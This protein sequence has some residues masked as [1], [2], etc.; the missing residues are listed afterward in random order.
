ML[1][2]AVVLAGCQGS[3]G[4]AEQGAG[5]T[6]QVEQ[7]PAFAETA[8]VV[9]PGHKPMLPAYKLP[10]DLFPLKGDSYDDFRNS[11]PEIY[12]ITN[13]PT[14]GVRPVAEYEPS[15]RLMITVSDSSL[16]SGIMQNL[17]DVVKQSVGIVDIYVIYDSASIKTFFQNKL[18]SAG[19]SGSSVNWVNLSNE[20]VWVRDYGP[21]PIL[22]NDGKVGMVDFRYYHERIEDD[23]VPAKLASLWNVTAYRAPVDFEGGN[24]M[25][26]TKGN[27]FA[28]QGILWYNGSA[29]QDQIAGYMKDYVG[30]QNLYIV[31]PL[32]GEG[33][34]HIDMQA[35]IVDDKTVVVGEY[36][37]NQDSANY[38][39]TNDNAAYIEGLGYNVVRMPMP[40]NSDG[41]FRTYIN[42]LFVNNVNLVPVYSIDKAKETQ[43]MAVWK[44]VMPTWT[45]VALNSD[46]VIK[47]AGA[48][49]CI[50]MTTGKGT[51]AKIDANPGYA[52]GGDWSC[53]PGSST[54]SCNGVSYQGCCEGALLK[55]CENGALK[56]QNCGNKP[57]CG[58]DAQNQFYNCGTNG[59]SD[60]SGKYPKACGGTCQPNCAGKSC[61][62]DG[63]G[64]SC[65]TCPSGQECSAGKC[66]PSSDCK[67]PEQPSAETCGSVTDVGCCDAKGRVTYCQ[68]G[69][70]YCID[71][72]SANP[73]CGWNAQNGWYD[74]GT[75]G[76]AD[77]SDA[78]PK[79]CGG[80]CQP[81]CTGKQCG[82]NGCGGSCGTCQAGYSC[83][84]GK[85]VGSC[86]PSC[87]G[88]Q[89]GDNGCGGSCGTCQAG[90]SCQSGKCVSTCQPSC[91]GKSCGDDGCGGSCGTCAGGTVCQFGKC[92]V[93]DD[94]C[95]GVSFEGCCD[96]ATLHWCEGGQVNT[97]ECGQYGCGWNAGKQYYDCNQT[98]TDPSGA[99]PKECP[100]GVCIPNC[101]GKLCGDDGCGGSCGTCP[102]GTACVSGKCVAGTSCGDVTY[103]GKC[104]GNVLVWC[105]DDVL[106]KADCSNLGPNFK[107]EYYQAYDGYYCVEHPDC[108][109][110]CTDKQCGD[111]GCGGSCGPCPAGQ[112]CDAGKCKPGQCQP[113]CAGKQCGDDGCGGSCGV[114]AAGQTCKSGKCEAA[115]VPA[116]SGKD[117]G[118]DGCGGSCGVCPASFTCQSSKCLPGCNPDCTAKECGD[119]GCGGLCGACQQGQICTNY[120]CKTEC[121]PSCDGRQCGPDG[122]GG[123]CGTCPK[124]YTCSEEGTCV[125]APEGCGNITAVGMCDGDS[126]KKCVANTVVTINCA[127]TGKVCSFVP[128]S[129][130]YDC[131]SQCIPN[132]SGKKCGPDG[133]NGTCGV[134]GK[135]TVCENYSCVEIGPQCTPSCSGKQCGDDSCG[136]SCGTCQDGF[137]CVTGMCVPAEEDADVVEQ[138]AAPGDDTGSSQQPAIS[139]DSSGCAAGRVADT[140]AGLPLLLVLLCLWAGRVA[141]R[142]FRTES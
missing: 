117:C 6:E 119:D 70:L 109:P 113:D 101:A 102:Q 29:S 92:V 54:D 118:P 140:A 99:N 98:G 131:V 3:G 74:C 55:W 9:A 93:V 18:T 24:F 52:C 87:T 85:C 114:C 48:I 42:S 95:F 89:C 35:K 67:G 100:G 75:N 33:T 127:D 84:S 32:D 115:C 80:T 104:E 66:V 39:I 64:G 123:S 141:V 25:A 81:N 36:L 77:P 45:H 57:Q 11:H 134:C 47:W 17:V 22:S 28:S 78:N 136:G 139:K 46:D 138:D 69:K 34:T 116:C 83:Q 61:G 10:G 135:G 68:N 26:D 94:P 56:T 79:A 4:S 121:K 108:Q 97:L 62:D 111:D 124:E 41:N 132:C 12:G 65:G 43:A 38:K 107:C 88:K 19:V 60:P 49:H 122:C 129:G 23:A 15:A 73:Q 126:L 2:L 106:N 120:K 112:S 76:A 44:Q 8:A 14:V 7:V 128:S 125:G 16:P 72:A 105:E 21:V 63:C 96:G 142:S 5:W 58:W 137:W 53:Y 103:A 13:P 30:C 82:D 90:Y 130:V 27:C 86:Q 133:C 20:T 51:F 37:A 110:N 40:S 71:C 59:G 1:V 91:A 31:K 50:T